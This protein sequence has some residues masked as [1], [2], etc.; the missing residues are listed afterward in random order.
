MKEMQMKEGVI[1][2]KG[3]SCVGNLPDGTVVLAKNNCDLCY[4]RG[5][6]GKDSRSLTKK[7]IPCSCLRTV[8][9]SESKNDSNIIEG[10]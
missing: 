7:M 10:S 2:F 4:G 6:L 5:C 3:Y 8:A 9:I 1:G